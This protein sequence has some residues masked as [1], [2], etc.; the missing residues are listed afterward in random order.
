MKL[1]IKV[2]AAP[3]KGHNWS[4]EY[5]SESG[6]LLGKESIS[7]QVLSKKLN[8]GKPFSIKKGE[9][10]GIVVGDDSI[11]RVGTPKFLRSS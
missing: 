9:V 8:G 6:E 7:R 11:M 1:Y 3:G 2:V 5:Y 10:W 4:V